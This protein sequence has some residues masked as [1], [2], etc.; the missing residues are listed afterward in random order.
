LQL[1]LAA[2]EKRIKNQHT[3]P[4]LALLLVLTGC[5]LKSLAEKAG[6]GRFHGERVQRRGTAAVI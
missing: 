2:T 6:S 5:F 3:S 4:P 1:L